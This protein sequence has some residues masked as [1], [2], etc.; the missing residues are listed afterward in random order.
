MTKTQ[1]STPPA[2]RPC[3]AVVRGH[4]CIL[5]IKEAAQAVDLITRLIFQQLNQKRAPRVWNDV[6]QPYFKGQF[7]T[8]W[9]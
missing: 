8:N 4:P 5:V 7:S 2:C 1:G 9:V 3:Q 6:W